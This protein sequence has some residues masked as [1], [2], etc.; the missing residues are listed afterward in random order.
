[1]KYRKALKSGA[2]GQAWPI[3]KERRKAHVPM[4]K[5]SLSC[6]QAFSAS[7]RAY[8]RPL[9]SSALGTAAVPQPRH[10]EPLHDRLSPTFCAASKSTGMGFGHVSR[11]LRADFE[12][13]AYTRG[14]DTS[15]YPQRAPTRKVPRILRAKSWSIHEKAICIVGRNTGPMHFTCQRKSSLLIKGVRVALRVRAA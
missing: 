6:Y 10:S 12:S 1:M 5:P 4:R 2:T 3:R 15:V 13:L 11:S 14:H 8:L 9:I 7:Q